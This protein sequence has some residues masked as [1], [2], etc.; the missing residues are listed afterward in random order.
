MEIRSCQAD[1]GT[2]R[3]EQDCFMDM[4][5]EVEN[6][7]GIVPCITIGHCLIADIIHTEKQGHKQKY[8]EIRR[9]ISNIGSISSEFYS[10]I[11]QFVRVE[12][13]FK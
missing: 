12:E 3:L 4:F 8:P 1:S 2:S 10:R 5:I 11:I 7:W 13:G 6:E 9:L